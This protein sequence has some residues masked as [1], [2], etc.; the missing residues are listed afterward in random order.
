IV[1]ELDNAGRLELGLNPHGSVAKLLED[2][3]ACAVDSVVKERGGPAWDRTGHEVLAEA[4]AALGRS[5]TAEVV[6]CV[7]PVLVA[8]AAVDRGLSGRASL[9]L[10]PSLTDMKGQLSRLVYPG[11][12]SDSG[13]EALRALP[14]YLAALSHRLDRLPQDPRRD[15]VL[16]ASMAAVQ[17][18]YL[19][20]VQG[21]PAG[22]QM[23]A[24]LREVGWMI[25]ELR[26]SLFAQHLKT[27][28]P[29]SVQRVEKALA[30][31]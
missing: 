9:E 5:R 17:S 20:Q 24:A 27:A 13:L 19:H 11:F 21:V 15:A 10:L 18:A 14:R 31:L 30:Q 1:K 12:I 8:A 28:R 16:T 29:V 7:R 4:V 2:C 6:Q 22:R 23:P 26:V 25:E 3:Y